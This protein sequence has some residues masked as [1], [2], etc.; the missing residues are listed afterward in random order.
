MDEKQSATLLPEEVDDWDPQVLMPDKL[1]VAVETFV[2]KSCEEIKDMKV[3][4][5]NMQ[6]LMA[7]MRHELEGKIRS[8]QDEI[9]HKV[10][11]CQT[12]R[13]E[14]VTSLTQETQSAINSAVRN[15]DEEVNQIRK[16]G[17]AA[18]ISVTDYYMKK[19]QQVSEKLRQL[20]ANIAH[21]EEG[22]LEAQGSASVIGPVT[23]Q[24]SSSSQLQSSWV[25]VPSAKGN[26]DKA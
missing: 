4:M 5:M 12:R 19:M 8:L 18:T 10:T 13:Q 26:S 22:R 21:E 7:T 3:K 17:D 6:N 11:L 2:V 15:C 23:S 14:E 25:N 16:D 20:S 1:S 24:V 9:E